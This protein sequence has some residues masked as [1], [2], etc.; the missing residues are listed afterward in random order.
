[1]DRII[2]MLDEVANK[3]QA[4]GLKKEAAEID[5]ISNTIEVLAGKKKKWIQKA[6]PES[7]EGKF[8]KWCKS[9]GFNGVCQA[10][11]NKAVDVGG[12]AQ[13]MALFAVNVSNGKYTYPDKND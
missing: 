13:K 6:V 3:V 5:K 8:E 10:C 4:A 1:M 9:N 7:H 2:E 12:N 11:I